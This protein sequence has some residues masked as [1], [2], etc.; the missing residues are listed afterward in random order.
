MGLS[1]P[2]LWQVGSAN[3]PQHFPKDI[4]ERRQLVHL[5]REAGSSESPQT[6]FLGGDCLLHVCCDALLQRQF[7]IEFGAHFSD[8]QNVFEIRE[9]LRFGIISQALR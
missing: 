9:I 6:I 5:V 3:S 4:I 8:A 7:S 2:H 1:S